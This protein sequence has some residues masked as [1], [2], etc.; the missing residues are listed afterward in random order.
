MNVLHPSLSK[1]FALSIC[2]RNPQINFGRVRTAKCITNWNHDG[3]L[4][5]N[6]CV[7]FF[8]SKFL[9]TTLRHIFCSPKPSK[10]YGV[11]SK[12]PLR[13]ISWENIHFC[14]LKKRLLFLMGGTYKW[15]L[16][17]NMLSSSLV[18]N[19]FLRTFLL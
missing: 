1:S 11:T 7:P 6:Y 13:E 19:F 9:I 5:D 12:V 3:S 8:K 18:D 2:N 14:G 17:K 10:I 4:E 15:I 16:P